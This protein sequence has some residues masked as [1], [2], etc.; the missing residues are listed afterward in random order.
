MP[1]TPSSISH[2]LSTSRGLTVLT[3]GRRPKNLRGGW[4]LAC[5]YGTRRG[6]R[7]RDRLC[8]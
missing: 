2:L 7:V 1:S 6:G 4:R 3:A 8:R 5:S